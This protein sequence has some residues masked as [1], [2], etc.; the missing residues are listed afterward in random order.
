MNTISGSVTLIEGSGRANILLPE[1]TN[2]LI[3]NALYSPKSH[4]NLLSFKDIRLNDHPIETTKWEIM[5][6]CALLMLKWDINKFWKDYL[7][8]LRT[9]IIHTLNQLK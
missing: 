1:G 6:I 8:S 5:S 3:N 4:R 9:F 7:F 2:F